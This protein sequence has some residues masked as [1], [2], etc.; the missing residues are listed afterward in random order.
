M[1]GAKLSKRHG[2]TSIT[3]Y[4]ALGLLP[5][6]VRLALAKLS[7]TPKVGGKAAESAEEEILTDA[8]MI[9][10]F[11]LDDIQKSPAR[12]D[13]EKL[14]WINQKL[15]QRSTWQELEP[16]LRPFVPDAWDTK[17]EEWK[18]VAITATQKGKSLIEMANSLA[19]CWAAPTEFE[20]ADKF[21]T[22][23]IKPAL[24]EIAALSN[25][26]H[27]PL[28]AAFNEILQRHG[29]KTKDL[30][31]ALRVALCGKPISP[32]IFDTLYLLGVEEVRAR[33]KKWI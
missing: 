14:T 3:E 5:G 8:Q 4:Q 23:A 1:D 18:K 2:A 26:E 6:A 29:L 15:I 30:A 31:Q 28:H 12:F 20:G 25:Y 21:M 11:D 16:R 33:V 19:F 22:P 13:M 27:D 9:E 17:P 7:W 24:Q 10:Y 32:G